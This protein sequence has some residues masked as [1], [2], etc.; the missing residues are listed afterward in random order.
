[1]VLAVLAI[2]QVLAAPAASSPA[3]PPKTIITVKSTALCTGLRENVAPA[4]A[5]LIQNDGLIGYGRSTLLNI[6]NEAQHAPLQ[7]SYNERGAAQPASSTPRLGEG[8]SHLNDLARSIAHNAATIDTILSDKA[9]F[10]SSPSTSDE[11]TLDLMKAQLLSVAR[12]QR[13]LVNV[14][15]GSS[16][17]YAMNDFF[18]DAPGGG[19][20]S[21]A[22]SP[23]KALEA[24]GN[25]HDPTLHDV[26]ATASI[27]GIG[28]LTPLYE[29]LARIVSIGQRS[30]ANFEGA[31]AKRITAAVPA[32]R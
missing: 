5:G 4:L 25:P 15:G 16:E 29:K 9:R 24:H 19:G 14:L 26:A 12:Q 18:N 8:F 30:I 32:C 28:G 22:Q 21:F 17:T 23:I 11:K 20:A 31:A 10:P 27:D 13:L 6:A 1:M 3:S 2:A 7:S